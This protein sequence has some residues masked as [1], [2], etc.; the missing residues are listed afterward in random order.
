MPAFN[1]AR[2]DLHSEHAVDSA[3]SHGAEIAAQ[4]LDELD[5]ETL[6]FVVSPKMPKRVAL[7]FGCGLGVQG[8][9]FAVLG[10]K[11]ILYD[12]VDIGERVERIKQALGIQNL[13]FK[14]IDLR[15]AR[16]ED[17]PT[18]IG[19]AYSQR[20]IHHLRFEEA[21]HL[22]G[23]LAKR[24]C[25]NGRLFI[26]A[27]GLG[28]EL[29]AGYAASGS[30]IEHRYAPLA[31]ELQG[32]HGIREPVCLYAIEDLERLVLAHGFATIRT[33]TTPFGN[34]KGVFER[35]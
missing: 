10:C 4:W 24:V 34:V 16:S 26:S 29:G 22:V 3:T 1:P 9:R 7:D 15:Q 14:Q 25:A 30:A 18:E 17:F 2:S 32:K 8:V 21:S 31:A 20:F 11:S 13:E 28:S 5:R 33:W 19:V 12:V 23:V 35:V 6:R 27:S